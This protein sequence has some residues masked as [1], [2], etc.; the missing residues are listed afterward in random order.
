[1]G[2]PSAYPCTHAGIFRCSSSKQQRLCPVNERHMDHVKLGVH[3]G[4]WGAPERVIPQAL[5][6]VKVIIETFP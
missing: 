6:E 3:G 5:Y 2:L 4:R 1:M